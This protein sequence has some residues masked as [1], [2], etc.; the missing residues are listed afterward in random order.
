MSAPPALHAGDAAEALFRNR[1]WIPILPKTQWVPDSSRT[2]CTI[3]HGTFS[4]LNRRHHCR[5]CGGLVCDK[6]ASET[7]L[8]MPR[9]GSAVGGNSANTTVAADAR[10]GDA[11]TW[12]ALAC[13]PCQGLQA[14]LDAIADQCTALERIQAE[15]RAAAASPAESTGLRSK[16][17]NKPGEVAQAVRM[18]RAL[19]AGLQQK[20]AGARAS[21]GFARVLAEAS[22]RVTPLLIGDEPDSVDSAPVA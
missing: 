19:W 8:A 16:P 7:T 13:Q 3:C 10:H 4:I 12:R 21:D 2:D 22:L 11:H 17:G 5:A 15:A 6:C 18:L 14:A 1:W 20:A 9:D